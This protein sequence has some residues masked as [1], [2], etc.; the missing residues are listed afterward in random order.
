M[1]QVGDREQPWLV[2]DD[3]GQPH[4]EAVVSTVS[5]GETEEHGVMQGDGAANKPDVLPRQHLRGGPSSLRPRPLF[6]CSTA[7][8]WH[9]PELGAAAHRCGNHQ[10]DPRGPGFA[11][12]GIEVQVQD[13]DRGRGAAAVGS[14]IQLL[15]SLMPDQ[16]SPAGSKAMGLGG[17]LEHV[18]WLHRHLLFRAMKKPMAA[19]DAQHH[20]DEQTDKQPGAI[21]PG[22]RLDSDTPQPQAKE[23]G[24]ACP[25]QAEQ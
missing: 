8:I 5:G 3:A 13:Q 9:L 1:A 6:Y 25:D 2:T 16:P 14:V 17:E 18:L 12:R 10:G 15:H 21:Q 23:D 4:L 24:A 20:Q 11:W 19:P 22:L 7:S